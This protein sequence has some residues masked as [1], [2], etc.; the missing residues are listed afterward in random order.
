MQIMGMERMAMEE[1][2]GLQHQLKIIHLE[3]TIPNTISKL[4]KMQVLNLEQA[5][6]NPELCKY[7]IYLITH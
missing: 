7:Y 5:M 3:A 2:E 1:E 6:D 4:P